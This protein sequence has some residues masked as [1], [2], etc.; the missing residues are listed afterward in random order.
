MIIKIAKIEAYSPN[1]EIVYESEKNHIITIDV[2]GMVT[3]ERPIDV[4]IK[5]GYCI[6]A[7]GHCYVISDEERYYNLHL[8]MAPS[9]RFVQVGNPPLEKIDFNKFKI[10]KPQLVKT[11]HSLPPKI[12]DK[13]LDILR[14]WEKKNE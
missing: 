14:E 11:Y 9:H 2:D 1:K 13:I 10:V 4:E 12:E 3:S 7:E 5:A 6:E 8:P